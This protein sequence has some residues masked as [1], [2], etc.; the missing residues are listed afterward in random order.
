MEDGGQK[1]KVGGYLL[2][3]ESPADRSPRPRS[4]DRL[5]HT[6]TQIMA[7]ATLS[8]RHLHLLLHPYSPSVCSATTSS[9]R[10]LLL[11]LSLVMAAGGKDAMWV[12][13][14]GEAGHSV[15]TLQLARPGK[16]KGGA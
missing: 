14:G 6:N 10:L 4:G 7:A 12:G 9:S 5:E 8:N 13:I 15:G 1:F 3:C 11:T 16:V 2:R